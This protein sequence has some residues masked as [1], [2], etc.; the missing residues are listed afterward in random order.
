MTAGAN[1]LFMAQANNANG[2]VASGQYAKV[3]MNEFR[4]W[5][6]RRTDAEIDTNNDQEIQSGD[7]TGLVHYY[8]ARNVENRSVLRDDRKEGTAANRVDG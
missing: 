2:D 8:R 6:V 7:T 3:V 1:Y 4:F 5:N